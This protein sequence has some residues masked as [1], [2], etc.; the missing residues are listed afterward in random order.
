VSYTFLQTA[1][2]IATELR[3]SNLLNDAKNSINDAITEAS[4]TRFYFNEMRINF[5]T[6]I[7]VEYYDDLGLVE[8]DAAYYMQ[9]VSRYNV[10]VITQTEMDELATGGLT[11]GQLYSLSRYQGRL[12][13]YPIPS[14]VYTL[15]VDGYGK[16]LPN[17]LVADG[18]TNE[19]LGEGELYIRALAKRNVVRDIVRDYGEAKVLDSVA[20]DYKQQLIE[21]TAT[22]STT[23]TIRSTQF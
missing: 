10:D 13:L 15:N 9:G 6:A 22:K 19:W 16:L 20:E 17:P 4:K 1:T 8:L 7:G 2:R 5:N 18:D 14:A 21:A 11:G 23:D 3:R 12:R